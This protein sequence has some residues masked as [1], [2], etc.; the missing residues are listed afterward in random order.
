M[1]TVRTSQMRYRNSK[2][3]ENIAVFV[4]VVLWLCLVLMPWALLAVLG[5]ITGVVELSSLELRMTVFALLG[6][7]MQ[8]VLCSQE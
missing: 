2:S 7:V 3:V 5:H 1:E 4:K 8:T 6:A